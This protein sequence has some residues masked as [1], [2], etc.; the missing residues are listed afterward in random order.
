MCTPTD[1][2]LLALLTTRAH[3]NTVIF[4]LVVLTVRLVDPSAVLLPS[5]S[6]AICLP[7]FKEPPLRNHENKTALVANMLNSQKVSLMAIRR[8]FGSEKSN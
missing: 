7:V 4:N 6:L 3:K 1:W 8:S 2:T 5:L